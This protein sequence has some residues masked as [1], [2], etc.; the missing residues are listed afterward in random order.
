MGK[1]SQGGRHRDC[2]P[3]PCLGAR[4][5]W[6]PA[7]DVGGGLGRTAVGGGFTS[8]GQVNDGVTLDV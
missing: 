3:P 4:G 8:V 2:R 5:S 7:G 6:F 1:P